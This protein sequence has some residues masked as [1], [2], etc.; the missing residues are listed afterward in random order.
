MILADWSTVLVVTI[1]PQPAAVTA[2]IA[3]RVFDVIVLS[4]KKKLEMQGL[5][6]GK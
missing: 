1:L 4:W 3:V 5:V 2:G 6:K